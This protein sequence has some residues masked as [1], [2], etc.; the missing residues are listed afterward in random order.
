MKND[1]PAYDAGRIGGQD[2]QR[3]AEGV[4]RIDRPVASAHA[5][6]RRERRR[7]EVAIASLGVVPLEREVVVAQEAVRDHQVVRLVSFRSD[8]HLH[9]RRGQ[10]VDERNH[11]Q[12]RGAAP[13]RWSGGQRRAGTR[14][15]EDGDGRSGQ[16]RDAG[17]ARPRDHEQED[18]GQRPTA[19]GRRGGRRPAASAASPR[20]TVRARG[21]REAPGGIRPGSTPRPPA[22][23]PSATAPVTQPAELPACATA[24]ARDSRPGPAALLISPARRPIVHLGGCHEPHR[25]HLAAGSLTVAGPAD[26]VFLK[27]GG[28]IKGEIVEQRADAVVMEVGPGRL[29]LP[30]KNVA[31]IVSSTTDL[32]VYHARAAALAPGDVAG[33]LSLARL[34]AAARPRHPGPRSLRARPGRRSR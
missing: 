25:G 8:L 33:W 21:R 18:G 28:E 26:S 19:R 14:D 29:T 3:E 16:G 2:Q 1:A 9:A 30:M 32:G 7:M 10:A 24:W 4:Q 20:P 17:Q 11:G 27:G 31:R 13:S 6:V 12:E 34:G 5:I 15:H 23:T 22:A